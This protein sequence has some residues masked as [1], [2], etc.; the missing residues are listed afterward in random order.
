M[1][2][3]TNKST[4]TIMLNFFVIIISSSNVLLNSNIFQGFK[5]FDLE[6]KPNLDDIHL[7]K[8]IDGVYFGKM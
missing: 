8:Y 7:I 6:L 5:L 1:K 4:K 3:P 2:S